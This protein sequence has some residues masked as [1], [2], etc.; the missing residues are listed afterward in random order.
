MYEYDKVVLEKETAGQTVTYSRNVYGT[1]LIS[2]D[3]D[4]SKVFYLYNGHADV[5]QL[6]TQTGLVVATYDYDAFGVIIEETGESS[7]PYRYAGYFFDAE[8]TLYYLNSRFYDAGIARFLQEDTYYGSQA[9]PLSLN[10]YSYCVNNPLIYRDPSGHKPNPAYNHEEAY[11]AYLNGYLSYY[12]Y[13]YEA[14]EQEGYTPYP[15]WQPSGNNGGNNNTPVGNSV[16]YE[17]DDPGAGGSQLPTM[18]TGPGGSNTPN[19]DGTI[20]PGPNGVVYVD[21]YSMSQ[22]VFD[23]VVEIIN[24]GFSMPNRTKNTFLSTGSWTLPYDDLYLSLGAGG[25]L[26]SYDGLSGFGSYG[27]GFGSTWNRTGFISTPAIYSAIGT[28]GLDWMQA[29]ATPSVRPAGY[30]SINGIFGWYTDPDAAEFGRSSDTYKIIYDLGKR[31]VSAMSE[32]ERINFVLKAEDARQH[33]REGTPYKYGQDIVMETMHNNAQLLMDYRTQ[34]GYIMGTEFKAYLGLVTLAVTAWDYKEDPDWQVEH[35][36]FNGV[37]MNKEM[38]DG[39]HPKNWTK[40][41]YF[42]GMMMAA[43]EF[44]NMNLGYVGAKQGYDGVLLY[45]FATSDADRGTTDQNTDTFWIEYGFNMAK[46]G[47]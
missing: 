43:D 9:D 25:R 14:K 36:T 22:P 38:P 19:Y 34:G 20:I 46:N 47:R 24:T 8:T 40:W 31:R 12:L 42:D 35:P 44:G 32:T 15:E 3:V 37:N 2:R 45:N 30:Y 5:V 21:R 10:L 27:F 11:Q 18:D 13:S 17:Q 4:G 41:I 6:V 28:S 7:N 16:D 33:A 29:P 39:S 23:A 26:P 1:N